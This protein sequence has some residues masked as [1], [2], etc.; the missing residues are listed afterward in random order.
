MLEHGQWIGRVDPHFVRA[1]KVALQKT[2]LPK[3]FLLKHGKMKKTMR[4]NVMMVAGGGSKKSFFLKRLK[5]ILMNSERDPDFPGILE[6]L[7]E[8]GLCRKVTRK[9]CDVCGMR[10]GTGV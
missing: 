2:M 6:I 8:A 3:G 9:D 1:P 4:E 10:E 5:K 7:K